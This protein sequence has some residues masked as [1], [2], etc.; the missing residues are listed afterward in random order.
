MVWRPPRPRLPRRLDHGEEA[1]LVEHLDELRQRLF[2]C[3]GAIAIGCVIGFVLHE[4]I[5]DW[6]V[7]QAPDKT[8][9]NQQD[10]LIT[11][12]PAEAFLTTL[13]IS[14]YFGIVI[15]LPVIFW[16]V[17]LFFVPAV[18]REHAKLIK[19]FVILAWLLA[20]VGI[21]FGYFVVIPAALNFLLNFDSDLF[22]N[23]LQAKPFLTFCTN[24]SL[25]MALVWELPLFVVALTRLGILK[26]SSLRKNRRLGYFIVVCLA[27]LLPG[28]DPV[29]V[30]FETLPLL[31]LFEA[32]IWL[33][34]LLDRRSARMRRTSGR[35]AE[36]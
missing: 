4:R 22:S 8:L 28:V 23:S 26:T 13:W 2:V 6:F 11:L 5:V 10:V 34:V 31:I 9:A 36:T 30:F 17:W 20:V 24:V 19:Y 14:I 7:A 27:V 12:T 16:Q 15:A 3:L 1:S 25:A 33:S 21:L 18:D 32:S 35:P 29:T